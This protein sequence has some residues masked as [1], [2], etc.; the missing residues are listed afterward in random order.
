MFDRSGKLE[1][2]NAQ[3]EAWLR[4]LP[5]TS[6][7]RQMP[8]PIEVLNVVGQARAIAAGRDS[9]DARVRVLSRT[10]RRLVI[11]ASAL[12]EGGVDSGKRARV[13][14]PAKAA[15]IAPIITEAYQLRRREQ[16]VTALVA[17][18]LSTAEMAAE[19]SP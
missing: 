11:H 9:G 3:A 2:L 13:I 17:R 4:E 19:L 16:Q 18:G 5:V 15:E 12:I 1:L 6:F 7:P 8:T 10:G 14:E